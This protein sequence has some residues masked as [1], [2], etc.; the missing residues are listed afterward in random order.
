MEGQKRRAGGDRLDEMAQLRNKEEELSRKKPKEEGNESEK[1]CLKPQSGWA[2]STFRFFSNFSCQSYYLFFPPQ[3]GGA[4]GGARL[5][6]HG[7]FSRSHCLLY[8]MFPAPDDQL[9]LFDAPWYILAPIADKWLTDW[10]THDGSGT[11]FARK[12]GLSFIKKLP[13]SG[14]CFGGFPQKKDPAMPGQKDGRK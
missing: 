14:R 11:F 3:D 2:A 1:P 8:V 6:C 13:V 4:V 10:S 9:F 7:S 5:C 12:I